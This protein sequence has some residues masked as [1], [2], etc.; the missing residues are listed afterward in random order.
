[1]N[2]LVIRGDALHSRASALRAAAVDLA[3][4]QSQA[5]AAAQAVG[6][7]GL[8]HTV[9]DFGSQW[10]LH[11]ERLIDE[12]TVLAHIFDAIDSTVADLDSDLA[13]RLGEASAR[14]GVSTTETARGGVR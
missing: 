11:R 3:T 12:I 1:M 13:S 7:R 5:D 2:D 4:A 14:A 9:R 8:A 6:H 10:D